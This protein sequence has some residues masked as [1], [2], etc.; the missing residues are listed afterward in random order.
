MAQVV[1]AIS[2]TDPKSAFEHAARPKDE[3]AYYDLLE[4]VLSAWS[5]SEPR[6]AL[7]EVSRLNID[8]RRLKFLELAIANS[9]NINEPKGVLDEIESFSRSAQLEIIERSL[10]KLA[11]TDPEAAIQR[12]QSMEALIGN[13]STVAKNIVQI[14]SNQQPNAAL[15]WVLSEGPNQNSNRAE[16]IETVLP[17]LTRANP[18]RAME[19][20]S[21]E[22]D[23]DAN[24]G[25]QHI[26]VLELSRFYV[27][28]GLD[29]L[30]GIEDFSKLL[31]FIWV[32]SALVR[33]GDSE[34]AI[35][36]AEQLPESV[37]QVYVADIANTWAFSQ[38]NEMHGMIESISSKDIQSVMAKVLLQANVNLQ[39]FTTEEIETVKSLVSSIE[40]E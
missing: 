10:K 16:L 25:L 6:T 31:S 27:D 5:H 13:T 37:Q 40:R 7:S 20:A 24:F 26:V 2:G 9:W 8:F 32:G 23:P 14:W 3:P 35:E 4:I 39:V 12:M 34:K 28:K 19:V 11:R 29:M 33:A 36:L 1:A 17:G 22:A 18:E 15:D 21:T 30:P 38:P